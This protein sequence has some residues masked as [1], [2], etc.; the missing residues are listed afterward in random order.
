[1]CK[2][3]TTG[4]FR[5]SVTDIMYALSQTHTHAH[6]HTHIHIYIYIYIYYRNMT[7]NNPQKLIFCVFLLL[8]RLPYQGWRGYLHKT[9]RRIAG[10][11]HLPRVLAPCEMQTTSSRY[12]TWVTVSIFHPD[13]RYIISV[14]LLVSHMVSW[15]SVETKNVN[16]YFN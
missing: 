3:M 8:D 6:T 16:D 7:L 9:G 15:I 10:G 5:N 2:Q 11:I 1:M 13:N 14:L 4:S 12:W